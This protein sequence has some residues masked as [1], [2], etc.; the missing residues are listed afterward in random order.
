MIAAL[1]TIG[2]L[3]AIA[4]PAYV[5]GVQVGRGQRRTR[6]RSAPPPR[7]RLPAREVIREARRDGGQHVHIVRG[8][9]DGL[10]GEFER[11][12]T[13]EGGRDARQD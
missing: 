6:G 2:V 8:F 1:V 13:Y 12:Q 3:L 11:V 4:L 5:A 10:A 9:G 7:R